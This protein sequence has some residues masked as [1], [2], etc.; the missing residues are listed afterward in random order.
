MLRASRWAVTS[1]V[2][3]GRQAKYSPRHCGKIHRLI[4]SVSIFTYAHDQLPDQSPR[5]QRVIIAAE[6]GKSL[7]L[8]VAGPADQAGEYV[9]PQTRRR[10]RRRVPGWRRDGGALRGGRDSRSTLRDARLLQV[11]LHE[12]L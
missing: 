8:S 11:R 7:C 3:G 4:V 10:H 5:H 6:K 9:R 2:G 1:A 12:A